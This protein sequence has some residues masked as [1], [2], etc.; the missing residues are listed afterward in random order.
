MNRLAFINSSKA[1]NPK[2]KQSPKVDDEPKKIV[3]SA[4]IEVL[5][6]DFARLYANFHPLLVLTI[7]AIRFNAIVAEPVRAL[8]VLLAPVGL[9]QFIYVVVCLPPTGSSTTSAS[10]SPKGTRGK[11]ATGKGDGSSGRAVVRP[12]Q[13][14]EM[15][16]L[17]DTACG[18]L[19]LPQHP[20]RNAP[21]LRRTRPLRCAAHLE[22]I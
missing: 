7:Y 6:S 2:P 15:T 11:K 12:T 20:P 21:N 8:T 4:P 17:T 1:D 14:Q 5:D 19:A 10:K 16:L 3:P 13:S 18:T 9:L 22:A